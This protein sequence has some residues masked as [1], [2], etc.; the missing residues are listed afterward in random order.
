M[1][2]TGRKFGL[3]IFFI[4]T[5]F[6]VISSNLEAL[7]FSNISNYIVMKLSEPDRVDFEKFI[8]FPVDFPDEQLKFTLISS[9]T[10]IK[11]YTDKVL[12][13]PHKSKFKE[14]KYNFL[15][16]T[17]NDNELF[18]KI[19][20]ILSTFESRNKTFFIYE[21]F[22]NYLSNYEKSKV[23]SNLKKILKD[24]QNVQYIGRFNLDFQRISGRYEVFLFTGTSSAVI[25]QSKIP[26]LFE[27]YSDYIESLIVTK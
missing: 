18:M 16:E 12:F 21:T 4:T 11:G 2:S 3:R 22:A 23:I 7:F 15:T 14:S 13:E 26:R 1:V 6:K 9:N 25:K 27:I 10:Q 19:S 24:N 20:E 17:E 8:G 5:S